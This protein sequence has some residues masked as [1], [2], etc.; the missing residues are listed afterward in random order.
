MLLRREI[1]FV[2]ACAVWA[3]NARRTKATMSTLARG[4]PHGDEQAILNS[5]R[6]PSRMLAALLAYG[7]PALGFMISRLDMRKSGA[8]LRPMSRHSDR[9][10]LRAAAMSAGS[11][12]IELCSPSKINLFLRI[13]RRRDDGYHDLASLFQAISL[14]DRLSMSLLPP[15]AEDDVF[16]CDMEG[17]PTDRTN[18]VLRA[19]DVFRENSGVTRKFK[20]RLEKTVPAQAGLGGGSGN[21][22]TALWGCNALCSLAA[23]KLGTDDGDSGEGG[24]S[25][26]VAKTNDELLAMSTTLGSDATFFLSEGTAYCTGRGEVV[27]PLPPLKDEKRSL[28]I[29]KPDVGLSTPAV[30]KA[31]DLDSR[32]TS[33]PLG[34][35]ELHTKSTDGADKYVND[36][37]P[38]AFS[39][40]PDLARLKEVLAASVDSDA[41]DGGGLGFP[42][43]SMSGSGT[44]IFCLGEPAT[45]EDQATWAARLSEEGRFPWPIRVFKA[46][47][48]N[49]QPGEWYT[50]ATKA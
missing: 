31:L 7:N 28:Y 44:S 48:L 1:A 42:V 13:V 14:S 30:F 18:L 10:E 22:A 43:V 33:D 4:S 49:R 35:L 16:E 27:T 6:N 39:C 32:S 8:D 46:D 20:I 17:V 5:L 26:F 38:P 25:G 37:E 41:V 24:I 36:L 23:Q 3:S 40:I 47:Y 12:D 2:L 19:V 15:D 29:V 45:G 9:A 21:A 11:W 50:T 34:L